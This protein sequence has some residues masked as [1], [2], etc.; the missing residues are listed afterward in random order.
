MTNLEELTGVFIDLVA[1]GKTVS[2]PTSVLKYFFKRSVD[3][4]ASCG[5]GFTCRCVVEE[6]E[7]I[8]L[9]VD[10]DDDVVVDDLPPYTE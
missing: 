8:D 10:D 4:M 7:V 2:V 9:T 3:N 5:C 1:A 6:T